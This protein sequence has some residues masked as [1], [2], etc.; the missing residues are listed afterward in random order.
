[1]AKIKFLF[2][3]DFFKS[4][5]IQAIIEIKNMRYYN[6]ANLTIAVESDHPITHTTFSGKFDFFQRDVPG[7]DI[8]TVRHHFQLPIFDEQEMRQVVYKKTPWTIY[9][10]EGAWIYTGILSSEAPNSFF[11][12]AV[13][14]PDHSRGDIFHGQEQKT[15]FRNGNLHVLTLFP[16]DQILLAR[17]MADRSACFLHAAGI[18]H[19]SAGYLFVGH[20]DAGKSTMCQMFLDNDSEILCDDRI[21]VRKHREGF[22]IH[23]TWSHGDIPNVSPNAAPLKGIYFL[24][25]ASENETIP[26]HDPFENV[27]RLLPCVIKGLVTP[28]WM[29]KVITLVENL[30]NE[31]PCYR[32]RFDKS[33]EIVKILV[34][35]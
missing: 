10:A 2:V 11:Q 34:N 9:K 6:I 26:I 18:V 13:F 35:T 1:L 16:T 25:Q 7:D 30:A 15:A 4:P 14:N 5:L 3:A 17:I 22:Y 19:D 21:I 32:L 12:A 31:I 33:G 28:D 23:G 8:V 29:E 27:K 24:E 20:S